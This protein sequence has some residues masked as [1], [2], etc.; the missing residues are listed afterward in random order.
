MQ[1]T[2]IAVYRATSQLQSHL[3][4][5][6]QSITPNIIQNLARP[7]PTRTDN[8]GHQITRQSS[9]TPESLSTTIP[10]TSTTSTSIAN[11]VP[12]TN[13]VSESEGPLTVFDFHF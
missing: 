10:G 9:D 11:S 3:S 7:Q 4:F 8:S 5:S 12:N 13:T 6:G 2:P 1:R